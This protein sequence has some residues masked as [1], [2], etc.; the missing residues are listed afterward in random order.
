LVETL[1][2]TGKL[3]EAVMTKIDLD[4]AIEDPKSWFNT[5]EEVLAAPGL[6]NRGRLAIL[7]S[8]ERDARALA[9]AEEESMGGGEPDMLARIIRAADTLKAEPASPSQA[10]T[11][12]GVATHGK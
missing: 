4:E 7:E 1:P 11:K 2:V 9:V 6:D 12:H 5:P 10:A 8:W 3:T